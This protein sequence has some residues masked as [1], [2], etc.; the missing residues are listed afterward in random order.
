MQQGEYM[1][2]AGSTGNCNDADGTMIIYPCRICLEDETDRSLVL[3]P[4]SCSGSQKWVHRACLDKWRATREDRAFSQC[5][6]CLAKYNLVSSTADNPKLVC[7]RRCKYASY[8]LRDF[9]AA[10]VISQLAICLFAY[11]VYGMDGRSHVLASLL[12]VPKE[13]HYFPAFYYFMGLT[14][15][16][17]LVGMIYACSK[18]EA[19]RN[20]DCNGCYCDTFYFW[21]YYFSSNS[22]VAGGAAAGGAD[23]VMTSCCC[24][25]QDCGPA[26]TSCMSLD[27][28]ACFG[29]T[30]AGVTLG[31]EA[32]IC[33]AVCVVL[34]AVIG[35]VV[36]VVLGGAFV[37]YVLQ[38]H[39]HIL[40]KWN[41]AKDYVVQDLAVDSENNKY[42]EVLSPFHGYFDSKKSSD[43]EEERDVLSSSSSHV[44]GSGAGR[45]GSSSYIVNRRERSNI[46]SNSTSHSM[47]YPVGEQ[48]MSGR[49]ID[50][51]EEHCSDDVI[52]GDIENNRQRRSLH[53]YADNNALLR[54]S[55]VM[56]TSM[57]SSS[58]LPS[59]SSP[60]PLT[61][62]NTNLTHR[63]REEL[64]RLGLL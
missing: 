56:M 14:T 50:T 51:G 39:M 27:C 16:L 1:S 57:R 46:S 25:C 41:L 23:P 33:V 44:G 53:Y 52:D 63:Q 31:E 12:G 60:S 18:I 10:L 54:P 24:C 4:C 6:E 36:A 40:H 49:S 58:L 17:S 37:Q 8:L 20:I 28:G 15:L 5:T 64:L 19:C 38:K 45:V 55:E 26:C 61:E 34:F 48:K 11:S 47:L 43:G 22:S 21:P 29:N 30:C 9:L 2:L 7:L 59:T 13:S 42:G 62:M 35:V 3:A 32:F